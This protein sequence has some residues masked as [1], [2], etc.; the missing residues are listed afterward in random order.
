[1]D[2]ENIRLSEFI[3]QKLGEYEK[4]KAFYEY[5]QEDDLPFYK[6]VVYVPRNEL[7]SKR[8]LVSLLQILYPGL[9]GYVC[10]VGASNTM[11]VIMS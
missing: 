1:M 9:F 4:G 8:Q 10:M 11:R 5:T 2:D 7:E 6:E 3:C